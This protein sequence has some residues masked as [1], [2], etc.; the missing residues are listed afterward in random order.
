M[1]EYDTTMYVLTMALISLNH[2][3]SSGDR[4]TLEHEYA[5]II[6]N[7]DIY[8]INIDPD[9][10]CL[11]EEISQVIGKRRLDDEIRQIIAYAESEQVSKSPW[12]KSIDKFFKSFLD[13]PKGW[14][15]QP[16]FSL[17]NFGASVYQEYSVQQND[18]SLRLN[19]E[20]LRVWRIAKQAPERTAKIAV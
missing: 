10:R 11:F 12:R 8:R 1:P 16:G 3:I 7:L 5:D 20:E 18:S 9:F 4:V 14:W 13:N 15:E 19:E 2:I 17:F 6:D